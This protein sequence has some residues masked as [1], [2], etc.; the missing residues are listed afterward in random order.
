MSDD[1]TDEVENFLDGV[2]RRAKAMKWRVSYDRHQNWAQVIT[3]T[4][5][6]LLYSRGVDRPTGIIQPAC[7]HQR[8]LLERDGVQIEDL[9]ALVVEID[10]LKARTAKAE[11]IL[12]RLIARLA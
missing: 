3:P 5:G 12:H 7:I 4:G 11:E 9:R 8:A 10:E 1:K 2:I 6:D